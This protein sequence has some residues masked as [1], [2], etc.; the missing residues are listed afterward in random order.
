MDS[1]YRKSVYVG[2]FFAWGRTKIHEITG[3]NS[4][5]NTIFDYKGVCSRY[6]ETGDTG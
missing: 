4:C 1:E 2:E 6:H 5:I 3:V